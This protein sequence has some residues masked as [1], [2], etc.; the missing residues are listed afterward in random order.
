MQMTVIIMALLFGGNPVWAHNATPRTVAE[1]RTQAA[2]V[3]AEKTDQAQALAARL[4]R[5]CRSL[6]QDEKPKG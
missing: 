2:I 1:C 6:P 4:E 5:A 3:A